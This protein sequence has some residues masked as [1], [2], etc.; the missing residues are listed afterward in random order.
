MTPSLIYQLHG[1]FM[2]VGLLVT[3]TQSYD[4]VT[5][6]ALSMCWGS[7]CPPTSTQMLLFASFY[8]SP[9]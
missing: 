6:A 5:L 4:G 1:R 9:L 8:A 3:A 2:L 7:I